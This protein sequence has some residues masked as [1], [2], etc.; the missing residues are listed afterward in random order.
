[1]LETL[2]TSKTRIKLILKF[3]LNPGNKAYLRLLEEEFA[4]STN[5]IRLE[6]NRLEEAGML[7]SYN[8]G[9]KKWYQVNAGHPLFR[10]LQEIVEKMLG[11]DI[12]IER[13]LNRLGNIGRVYLVGK[14]AQ[15]LDEQVIHIL[16][17]GNPDHAYLDQ[18]VK[19]AETL[20]KRTIHYQITESLEEAP[21]KALLIWENQQ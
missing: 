20:L 19:K 5:A 11:I 7:A 18:L 17:V 12:I 2:I 21:E 6:L 15:G 16:I 10:P 1:M 4:E 14:L 3:F 13:I 9:N 8:E